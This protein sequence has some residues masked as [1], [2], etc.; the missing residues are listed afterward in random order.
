MV[1]VQAR[2]LGWNETEMAFLTPFENLDHIFTNSEQ[3][4]HVIILKKGRKNYIP[5][6]QTS[7]FLFIPE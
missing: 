2:Y 6:I 3:W 5:A 7:F 4:A 1:L